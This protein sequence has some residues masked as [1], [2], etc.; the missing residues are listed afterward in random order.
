MQM[1]YIGPVIHCFYIFQ[2]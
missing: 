1:K 2:C